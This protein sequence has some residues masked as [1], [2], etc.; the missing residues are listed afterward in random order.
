M[1]DRA[2]Q[3][4]TLMWCRHDPPREDFLGGFIALF[5]GPGGFRSADAA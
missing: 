4:A 2:A 1:L 5:S 3:R